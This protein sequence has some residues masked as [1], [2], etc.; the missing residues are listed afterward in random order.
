MALAAAVVFAISHALPAYNDGSGFDCFRVTLRVLVGGGSNS[1]S[2]GGFYYAG[3]AFANILF[4]VLV[5][6]LCVTKK[7]RTAR[8][9]VA[10]IILL[11]VLSWPIVNASASPP[12][13]R[14]VKIGY[15][16]WL[17]AYGLLVVA[18]VWK[19]PGARVDPIPV[20]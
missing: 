6:A 20:T 4:A 12:T 16:L 2:G 15:Y 13:L 11:Q 7:W 17:I 10:L 18:H 14:D 3:F 8:T 5:V 19:E 1:L 9:V